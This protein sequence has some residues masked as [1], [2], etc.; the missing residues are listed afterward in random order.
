MILHLYSFTFVTH[1]E[2]MNNHVEGV[3]LRRG[4]PPNGHNV[5]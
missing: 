4:I 3:S 1:L 2:V 5:S